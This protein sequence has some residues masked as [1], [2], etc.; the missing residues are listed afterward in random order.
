MLESLCSFESG[1]WVIYVYVDRDLSWKCRSGSKA[2]NEWNPKFEKKYFCYICIAGSGVVDRKLFLGHPDPWLFC[3]DPDTFI[4]KQKS[5][6]NFYYFVTSFWRFIFDNWCGI[7]SAT[8][9]KSMIRI[10][11]KM[12]RIHNTGWDWEAQNRCLPYKKIAFQ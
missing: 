12:S 9:E 6:T 1:S 5:N 4:N 8:D 11:S 2:M 10:R 3:T 7:L